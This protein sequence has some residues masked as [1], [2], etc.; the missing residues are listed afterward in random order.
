MLETLISQKSNECFQKLYLL[1]FKV[2]DRDPLKD[3]FVM[4]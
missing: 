2:Y 4:T 1:I 3:V